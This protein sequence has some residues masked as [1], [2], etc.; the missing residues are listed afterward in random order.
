MPAS[1]ECFFPARIGCREIF[2]GALNWR[3]PSKTLHCAIRSSTRCFRVFCTIVSKRENCSPMEPIGGWKL[4]GR[5]RG[6]RVNGIFPEG[7]PRG[8]KKKR[9]TQRKY[10]GARWG[11]EQ[12]EIQ[13]QA[14][15][16]FH[17]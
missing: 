3:S 10:D 1:P 14:Y 17:L 15:T 12:T 6:A 16:H 7:P 11:E 4:R 8:G 13:E 9:G 2:S 5:E